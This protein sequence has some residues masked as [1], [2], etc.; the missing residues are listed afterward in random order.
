MGRT[1]QKILI[2]DQKFKKIINKENQTGDN[3]PHAPLDPLE[4]LGYLTHV[5]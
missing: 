3:R 5:P 1:N 4:R 2:I